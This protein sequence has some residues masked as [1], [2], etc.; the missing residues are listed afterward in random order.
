MNQLPSKMDNQIINLESEANSLYSEKVQRELENSSVSPEVKLNKFKQE[1][2]KSAANRKV[3]FSL[4]GNRSN[5]LTSSI[6]FLTNNSKVV[7]NTFS[8]DHTKSPSQSPS[9]EKKFI[10]LTQNKY[11]DK[12]Q[13]FSINLQQEELEQSKIHINCSE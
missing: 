10:S 9:K 11:Q 1:L 2:D 7:P 8:L 12:N 13:V 3:Q 5:T 4:Q 6:S